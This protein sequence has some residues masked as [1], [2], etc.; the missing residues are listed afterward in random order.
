MQQDRNKSRRPSSSIQQNS[1]RRQG[2]P[3][4][5][6]DWTQDPA[7]LESEPPPDAKAIRSRRWTSRAAM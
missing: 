3:R 1:A 2:K 5:A 7:S 4:K 6:Y